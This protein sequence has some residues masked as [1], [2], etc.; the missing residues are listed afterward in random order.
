VP[1]ARFRVTLEPPADSDQ[2][3]II[4]TTPPLEPG[5]VVSLLA[6]TLQLR[7]TSEWG[8]HI[9]PFTDGP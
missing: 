1:R 7:P 6:L 2:E 3:P 5:E 8:I 4:V 9:K